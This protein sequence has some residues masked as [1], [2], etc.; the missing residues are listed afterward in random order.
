[1]SDY[2][3]AGFDLAAKEYYDAVRQANKSGTTSQTALKS[4]RDEDTPSNELSFTDM[5]QLMV[6]QFQN[7]TID[8]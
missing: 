3:G 8:K 7:Q 6:V 1:M 5:L 4:W 2:A